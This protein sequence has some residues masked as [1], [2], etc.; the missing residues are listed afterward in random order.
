M[1]SKL[2]VNLIVWRF[3]G[4]ILNDTSINIFLCWE[5]T[6]P[7]SIYKV[8]H[9]GRFGRFEMKKIFCQSTMVTDILK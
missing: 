6:L 8:S 5:F 7:T 4:L 3:R 2:P 1:S 9:L